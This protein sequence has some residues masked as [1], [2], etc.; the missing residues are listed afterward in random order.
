M[1]GACFG[2]RDSDF[3][4]RST[5]ACQNVRISRRACQ[6][7]LG[8]SIF[9]VPAGFERGH[10]RPI[11]EI[12]LLLWVFFGRHGLG[13]RVPVCVRTLALWGGLETGRGVTS[14]GGDF[15]PSGVKSLHLCAVIDK[16]KGLCVCNIREGA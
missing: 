11:T 10:L 3:G 4:L 16:I 2:F 13:G 1:I 12:P 15:A 5:G 6:R 14:R 7:G 9:G 8:K